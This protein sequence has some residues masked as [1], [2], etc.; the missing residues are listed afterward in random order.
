MRPPEVLPAGEPLGFPRCQRCPYV[1][2]GPAR[3]CTE[4]ASQALERIVRQAC[5]VCSQILPA[6]GSCPNWLCDD[7]GRRIHRIDAIAYLSGELRVRLHRYKYGGKS[8][9]SLIFGRLL[10]GWLEANIA[11]HRPDLIVANPT[12]PTPDSA[13]AGHVEAILR[14]A[15]REDLL[16][17]WPFDI[18]EPPTIV[19]TDTTQKSAGRTAAAKRTA[20]RELGAVLRI[21]DP[22]RTTGRHILV[23][24]DVC[25]TGSQLNAVAAC[26]LDQGKAA[27]VHGLVLARAPWRPR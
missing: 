6:D 15:A 21:P 4:C 13:G 12:Y 5:P 10:L 20:A 27:E 17:V 14:S 26:L 7:P 2:V 11:D 22:C 8:G 18:T 1:R 9:W 25:T 3:I 16:D 24:D 23:F 19:K